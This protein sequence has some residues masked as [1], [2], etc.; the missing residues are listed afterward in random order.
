ME[1][2]RPV[3]PVRRVDGPAASAGGLIVSAVPGSEAPTPAGPASPF[4]PTIEDLAN[5]APPPPTPLWQRL[6]WPIIIAVIALVVAGGAVAIWRRVTSPAP[7]QAG[8][9]GAVQVPLSQL[10]VTGSGGNAIKSLKVNGNLQVANSL[11]LTPTARPD[12]PVAGQLYYD[13]GSNQLAYYNGQQFVNTG[14]NGTVTNVTNILGGTGNPTANTTNGVLLQTTAPGTQQT[15]NFNIS[16]IGAV[17]SLKTSVINTGGTTLYINPV[18]SSAVTSTQA[19]TTAATLGLTTIGATETGAGINNDLI[20]TKAT[21]GDAGGTASSITV[22]VT[23][24]TPGKHIQ[25]ALYDDDGDVPSRPAGLLTTSNVVTF[26]PNAFNTIPIPSIALT[27]DATY[28]MAFSTDDT[29]LSRPFNG[30]NKGSCFYGLAFGFMPDPFAPGP[31]FFANELY[32]MYV[33]YTTTTG[34]AGSFGQALFSLTPTGQAKFQNTDD[35][36]TAFQI[37]NASGTSTVF[38]VDTING[39]IAIGKATAAYKLDIAAGDINLSNNRSIR[40]NGSQALTVNA[41]GTTTSIANFSTGGSVVAQA[42]SFVV[43]DANGFHQNLVVDNTGATTFSN[44]VNSATAFQVQNAAGTVL[45]RAD[46]SGLNLY[47]GN[48]AGSATPVVLYL[49]NKNTA[50]DPVGAAG[51]TYY[52]STLGAFRCFYSGFWHNCADLEPQ[53][54]FSLYDEFMSGQTALTGPVGSLGWNALAIGANGSLAL[55]P[56]APAPSSDRPGVLQIKTPAVANQGTTLLLADATGGSMLLAKDNDMKTAVAPGA[57]TGQVMRIGLDNEGGATTQPVSGVW[58]E[59][60]PA[61]SA[62]WRYC[63]GDGTTPTCTDSAVAIAAN[64]WATLE[65]RVTAIGAGTSAA[66]FV[67]NNTPLT[68]AAVTI[69][70]TNRVSPALSCY[71]TTAAQQ[72]CYWDYF[73]LTGTTSAVR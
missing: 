44:R 3:T 51:G 35:S 57:A 46:T 40:F 10:A 37:Q 7:V 22:Y 43:Q 56:A 18:A 38:N 64:T 71:A 15:G 62:N 53:H 2:D 6:R 45:L 13:Q 29:T 5:A 17:G 8:S 32:T 72:N 69:D 1:P 24:G 63:Y 41:A 28:W 27:P 67:I 48:P 30:A 47:V 36:T 61:A 58:W 26:T 68:V 73:Q 25:V 11:L 19:V 54:G 33:N 34:G 60:N 42:D 50:G 65:I 52:N 12:A 49:A 9:F 59:A 70:T 31:C 39:R 4:E 55:N 23:G 16:G 14:G 21:M 20:A 66:T